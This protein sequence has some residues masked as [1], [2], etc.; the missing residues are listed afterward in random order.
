MAQDP[1]SKGERD[2]ICKA[3]VTAPA[4]GAATSHSTM[5]PGRRPSIGQRPSAGAG[6]G[7][8]A[9]CWNENNPSRPRKLGDRLSRIIG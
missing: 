5:P 2:I 7:D 8:E 6:L 3:E 1:A 9:S 4:P